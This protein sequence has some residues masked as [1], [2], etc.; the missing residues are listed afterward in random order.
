MG[1]G[2]LMFGLR[3]SSLVTM[4]PW[5]LLAVTIGTMVGTHCFDYHS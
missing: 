5:V 1:T 3:N 4:N 2:A